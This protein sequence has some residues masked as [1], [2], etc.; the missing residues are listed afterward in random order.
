MR[1]IAVSLMPSNRKVNNVE[2]PADIPDQVEQENNRRKERELKGDHSTIKTTRKVA[3]FRKVS[4]TT[5]RQSHSVA[6]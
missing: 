5:L 2:L 4:F 6:S 1:R 3:N